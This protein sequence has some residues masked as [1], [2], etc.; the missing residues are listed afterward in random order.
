MRDP[1]KSPPQDRARVPTK[2]RGGDRES[3]KGG[4]KGTPAVLLV[5][6]TRRKGPSTQKANEKIGKT[7]INR[8]SLGHGRG[9]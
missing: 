1:E 2:E 6:S 5:R 3:K 8:E 7:P 4:K 9:V